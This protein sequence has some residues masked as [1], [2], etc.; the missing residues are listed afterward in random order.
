MLLGFISL[1]LSVG[2]TYVVKICIPIKL[3]DKLLPCEDQKKGGYDDDGD[4]RGGGGDDRRKLLSYAEE[5]IWRRALAA[6]DEKED[7]CAAQVSK[8]TNEGC[9]LIVVPLPF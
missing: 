2:T 8:L 3:G 5:I 7:H 9:V 1:L 6:G 4:K